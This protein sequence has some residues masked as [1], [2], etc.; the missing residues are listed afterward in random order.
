MVTVEKVVVVEKPVVVEKVV[1]KAVEAPA[2]TQRPGGAQ[3]AAASGRRH[4][5]GPTQARRPAGQPGTT[6]FQDTPRQPL[7]ATRDDAV[8]TFSLDTDRTSFQLALNWARAGH[9]VDPAVGA[10]R[11]VGERLRLRLRRAPHR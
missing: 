4:P 11:G 7:I 8:S 3:G 5:R 6:T 2:Q 9:R 10:R 1:E